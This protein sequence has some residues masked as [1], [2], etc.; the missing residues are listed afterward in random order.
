MDLIHISQKTGK[1]R[2]KPLPVVGDITIIARAATRNK[3]T[4]VGECRIRKSGRGGIKFDY[5][6]KRVLREGSFRIGRFRGLFPI[7]AHRVSFTLLR[8]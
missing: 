1:F 2:L 3:L 7:I 8:Q 4:K 6:S 5:Q